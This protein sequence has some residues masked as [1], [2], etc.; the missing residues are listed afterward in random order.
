MAL[1]GAVIHRLRA[2]FRRAD[3]RPRL[4]Q[5]ST[6]PCP[7][8]GDSVT[9]EILMSLSGR[10]HLVLRCSRRPECP[11]QCDQECRRRAETAIAAVDALIILP[12]GDR[13]PE[14]FG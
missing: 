9:A 13:L 11:P 5:R 7:H 4:V 14:H 2:I 1:L 8:G 10:P 3:A 6:F 12:P